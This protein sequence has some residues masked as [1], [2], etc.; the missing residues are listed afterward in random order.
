MYN[1]LIWKIQKEVAFDYIQHEIYIS[2]YQGIRRGGF[3]VLTSYHKKVSWVWKASDKSCPMFL[4][5]ATY[6]STLR[7]QP[8]TT[9]SPSLKVCN[10]SILMQYKGLDILLNTKKSLW[11]RPNSAYLKLAPF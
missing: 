3:D 9:T 5:L 8:K 4:I 6:V 10:S 2:S 11:E 1:I 7:K